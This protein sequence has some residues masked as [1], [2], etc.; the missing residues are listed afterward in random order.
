M[1][2]L[3][4]S[5]CASLI[6]LLAIG[7]SALSQ[8]AAEHVAQTANKPTPEPPNPNRPRSIKFA[9][10]VA[11]DQLI[12]YNR[13]G[14]FNP[15]GMIY[16]LR[17][18]VSAIGSPQPEAPNCAEHSAIVPGDGA[19]TAGNVA[20]KPCKRARPLVLRAN[21]GDILEIRFTNL[22]RQHQPD[23][24]RTFCAV[25]TASTEVVEP[26]TEEAEGE[27]A[28]APFSA[29]PAAS[30]PACIK[31]GGHDKATA[32]SRQI[33]TAA[34]L[35]CAKSLEGAGW[36]KEVTDFA[37]AQ[38][39]GLKNRDVEMCTHGA[40][41]WP[42]TR[43]ANLV[44][45]GLAPLP[46]GDADRD[47]K[48]SGLI[49]VAPNESVNCQWRVETTGTHLFSS[50]AAGSGG[51]GNGGSLTHGLFG[52]FTAEPEASTYYRSQYNAGDY[53]RLWPVST[54]QN[55]ERH[56][57]S[58]NIDYELEQAG[59]NDLRTGNGVPC[60]GVDSM[61]VARMTRSCGTASVEVSGETFADIPVEEVVYSDL[62]AIVRPGLHEPADSEIGGY[63]LDA[64]PFREFTVI[65]HDELKSYYTDQYRELGR[66]GQLAGVGD[67][68]AINYGASGLG[69]MLVANRKGIGPAA[70]CV[71][72]LYEE[73]F[74]ESW[75][76][77]DPALLEQFA[78]DP[79][80]VHHS[81]L[82]DR[83]VFR[84]LHA[85]PKETHVFHLHAH[86]WWAGNDGDRG[87]YLDSQTIGPQQGFTYEI[88]RGGASRWLGQVDAGSGYW[89]GLASG[90]RNRTPG[91]AIFH[92]HLYPHF[93]QGMWSLWRIHDVLE[94][95]SR[96]LP[97]GQA[98][99]GLS[100]V[101]DTAT[102]KRL[103]S[104]DKDGNWI[105]MPGTP[106]PGLLPLMSQP[107]PLL[108]TYGPKGMPGYPFYIPGV[109]GHR[110]PQPPLD[111]AR[112]DNPAE[113][114][115]R[116][117]LD[118]G[119]PRHVISGGERTFAGATLAE[120]LA[121]GDMTAKL[122]VIDIATL[123][124]DGTD[125]E[126]RA[127]A[128]HHDGRLI[129]DT[130]VNG[131]IAAVKPDGN[132][133]DLPAL[134]GNG[135]KTGYKTLMVAADGA[136]QGDA[137]FNVNGAPPKP[138]APF[139]D[140]CGTA[141]GFVGKTRLGWPDAAGSMAAPGTPLPRIADPLTPWAGAAKLV[142]DPALSGFRRFDVSALQLQL[143]VNRAGWHDPQARIAALSKYVKGEDAASTGADDIRKGMP[144][145]AAEPFFFRAFSGDCIELR[146][147][148]ETP[149]DLA[150][151]DFQMKV[152]TDTI[153]QH[154][155]LVKFDVT[156]SDGSGNGYN[157][158]D[159]TF[160]PGEIQKRLCVSRNVTGGVPLRAVNK[161]GPEC[162]DEF[163]HDVWAKDRAT[164]RQ[165]FQTT[166]QRWF[167]DP[168]LS[169]YGTDQR[170]GDR[171]M[172]TVFSHDHFAPSNIQQHGYYTALLIEPKG[173]QVKVA[174]RHA[175]TSVYSF[176]GATPIPAG[177]L[178]VAIK[179]DKDHIGTRATVV[180]DDTPGATLHPNA[181]EF[182][183]AVADFAL[184]YD[185]KPAS[186]PVSQVFD[187]STRGLDRLVADARGG[188]VGEEEEEGELS[189]ADW[190]RAELGLPSSANLT[191]ALFTEVRNRRNEIRMAW[192]KPIAPPV[193]PEAI[194][195]SHHD[196]YLLNYR[197]E[198]VP[199][200]VGA[201]RFNG[202]SLLASSL[203]NC[204]GDIR[205]RFDHG[206][207]K[208]QAK[209]DGG[210]MA[211]VFRSDI[212]GDPC[213][214]ILEAYHGERV[215]LRMVQ[216]AQEV[217][218]MFTIEGR[219]FKRNIDQKF[220]MG[221]RRDHDLTKPSIWRDCMLSPLVVDAGGRG[222]YGYPEFY[223]AWRDNRLDDALQ[224]NPDAVMI[225]QFFTALEQRMSGCDNVEGFVASQEVG[226][227]E[228]FEIDGVFS[229]ERPLIRKAIGA[230]TVSAERP[231]DSLF[232]L[233]SMDAIWNGAW[234]LIRI[235]KDENAADYTKCL[236]KGG[237]L[238]RTC[239]DV[240]ADTVGK[241]LNKPIVPANPTDPQG[242][243]RFGGGDSESAKAAVEPA[244][245]SCPVSAPI[246]EVVVVAAEGRHVLANGVNAYTSNGR[247]YDRDS[248]KLV[249]MTPAEAG[250]IEDLFPLVG[251]VGEFER[252]ALELDVNEVRNLTRT[253]LSGRGSG[254]H[255]FVIRA[256]AGECLR[257]VVVNALEQDHRSPA[258]IRDQAGDALMPPIVPLN[259]RDVAGGTTGWL[260]PSARVALA[261]PGSTVTP[262]NQMRLPV[263]LLE[264]PAVPPVGSS[265]SQAGAYYVE[266]YM[267]RMWINESLL[268][269]IIDTFAGLIEQKLAAGWELNRPD[270]AA[271]QCDRDESHYAFG[272]LYCLT[273]KPGA[274]TA[275]AA[276]RAEA[277]N[278]VNEGLRLMRRLAYADGTPVIERVYQDGEALDAVKKLPYA[279]GVLPIHS[280]GDIIGHD[281][282][283]LYGA[284]I[285][286][287]SSA[288]PTPAPLTSSQSYFPACFE[289]RPG[290]GCE[291]EF[292]AL[293]EKRVASVP[294][295]FSASADI[296]VK[297]LKPGDPDITV[298]EH[299]LLWQDGLNLWD[300]RGTAFASYPSL[301][302]GPRPLNECLVCDD[303][304]D[305]GDLAA[306]ERTEP[307]FA[308]LAG[309][310]V[311]TSL[312]GMPHNIDVPRDLGPAPLDR[313][314]EAGY[315]GRDIYNSLSNYN[316]WPF[317]KNFYT[318]D[319]DAP[320]GLS[321]P[322]LA[323]TPGSQV[324]LRVVQPAG[325]ARQRAFI[326]TGP[327]YS[328]LFPGF[329]AGHSALLSARK[330][331]TA[332]V[333]IPNNPA[334]YLWRDGP[335]QHFGGGVWGRMTVAP[336]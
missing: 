22:L 29:L 106:I 68:F 165:Y 277:H 335:A 3:Y 322:D 4:L 109:P 76:N 149:K 112:A 237:A 222:R 228:H 238:P 204:S 62:N 94:D 197:T 85:G 175:A 152:P 183:L 114:G 118:G 146:H 145:A 255:P 121:A 327:A 242:Q 86:Q 37:G 318:A 210:D 286:E 252:K 235:Y 174:A 219:A 214:P 96:H 128:F 134:R 247:L 169:R 275:N 251:N 203:N 21:V 88:Y 79:S 115:G 108:P 18:D 132:P 299:V 291:H 60:A 71:E 280:V 93:A 2:W 15:Y 193:R 270:S 224:G 123:P 100:L 205:D 11:L 153:G 90:N 189:P 300:R 131:E 19:L 209:G 220:P 311:A 49:G 254:P 305:W 5:A 245:S 73:F 95:G 25:E 225:K 281:S 289:E 163:I 248:L 10:V 12:V 179:A 307:F 17:R 326:F 261:I 168:M 30:Q 43:F 50:F 139:A 75:A 107:A 23:I 27:E 63:G 104:V 226:I 16:A 314:A 64:T 164:H 38:A 39:D 59:G 101:K 185:G 77:G 208:Y 8:N 167:A 48:C 316:A 290:G 317:P 195:T 171:T 258:G 272:L 217:Q 40:A 72:C 150:L 293:E 158:E 155:H 223:E 256:R 243:K 173:A 52:A 170:Y 74:L 319:Q 268:A 331:L 336:E 241:R 140:P 32:Q 78:S 323:A 308:R 232:N 156:S 166:A 328:D 129:D 191:G 178:N 51:E 162:S 263:G 36:R 239:L 133:A 20:L 136:V 216:G 188:F 176:A 200:R 92:C 304:Y 55:A 105:G 230:A 160:A 142:P 184:L 102:G 249:A 260:R 69:T 84:N 287:P 127:M 332:S 330:G 218:H 227:S 80:N 57:R 42:A 309:K 120:S 215:L 253:V 186:N 54:A 24:S 14:S 41:D 269:G 199:L 138:G 296:V 303:S 83:V 98:M 221:Y 273:R 13:F 66:F 246:R 306:N 283:G 302:R 119:L 26:E 234:G 244:A 229:S 135:G 99:P 44:I 113:N 262:Y 190:R 125:L 259:V 97:D 31:P 329:G 34:A 250:P 267:G 7:G 282:H 207:I 47:G 33:R 211:S 111:I 130:S 180:T 56:A 122:D 141:E 144:T 274:P 110:T 325:R 67:G 298:R 116:E 81:Y 154:I 53:T 147:T 231:A 324:W 264:N 233:G 194:S 236:A 313:H 266:I 295:D 285:V 310:T 202:D 334:T 157:Y 124:Y 279:F 172:R 117:F 6:S 212:H 45:P 288:G 91:D 257:L 284:L 65:F 265:Q 321:T 182:A 292:R 159:G 61:P 301:L 297:G 201:V 103:G 151:D 126:K 333:N 276:A 9:D 315:A 46:T 161:A 271:E 28:E 1:K 148:N 278:A 70:N 82:N 312:E 143:I 187:D 196:P 240:L 58:N 320:E 177:N 192:G 206:N 137:Y 87:A 213:T 198:P 294:A 89:E 35:E 181:R